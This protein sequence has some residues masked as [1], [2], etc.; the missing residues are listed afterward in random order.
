M[1][2]SKLTSPQTTT[3]SDVPTTITDTYSTTETDTTTVSHDLG[4]AF[5]LC[6]PFLVIWRLTRSDD[7]TL[8]FG[9]NNNVYINVHVQHEL[10]S[11]CYI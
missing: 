7:I 2:C 11:Y 1:T 8:D 6:A 4:L 10:P 9:N 5:K 3:T